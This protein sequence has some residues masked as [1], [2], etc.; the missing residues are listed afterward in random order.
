[1]FTDSIVALVTPF[2]ENLEIDFDSLEQLIEW[3]IE[4]GTDQISLCGTT[5]ESGALT[6]E[7]FLAVIEKAVKTARGRV[8]IIA[9]TGCMDT[10]TALKKTV[11]VKE[12]GA[13]A[14]LVVVPYYNR[15]T[16]EGCL[17]HFQ[18]VSKAGLPMI[19]YHHPGRT[20]L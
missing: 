4:E 1:M 17:A 19:V 9:G 3:H 16:E 12:I 13:D 7:E 8:P 6:H 10:R 5:G 11:E 14:A 18:E 2:H 15:P 20:G